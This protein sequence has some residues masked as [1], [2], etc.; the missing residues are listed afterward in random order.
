MMRRFRKLMILPV[1]LLML[2]GCGRKTVPLE[3][4]PSENSGGQLV[5]MTETEEEARQ[6]AEL[7]GIEF[8]SF[9]YGVAVFVTEED[10]RDVIRRGKEQGWPE[11]ALDGKSSIT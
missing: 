4:L 1:L 7:Y 11:L 3:T 2:S 8:L 5:C 6:I 10:P 9:R